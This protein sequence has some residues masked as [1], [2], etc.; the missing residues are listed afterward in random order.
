MKA[1]S[2]YSGIESFSL[3]FSK[4]NPELLKLSGNDGKMRLINDLFDSGEEEEARKLLRKT[5]GEVTRHLDTILT[6]GGKTDAV[7]DDTEAGAAAS[8]LL[9]LEA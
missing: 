6:E 1:K 9:S 8:L 4:K 5:L 2:G 3:S 7:S